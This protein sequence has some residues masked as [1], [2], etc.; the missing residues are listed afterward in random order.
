MYQLLRQPCDPRGDR[1]NCGGH[2]W[3]WY[4]PTYPFHY[5]FPT[6]TIAGISKRKASALKGEDMNTLVIYDSHYGNTE[7]V[8]QII[9]DTLR[10]FGQA[11]AVRV[12]PA[13]DS[14][15]QG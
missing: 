10:P 12:D 4:L 11:R 6:I 1:Y 7:R 13:R 2:V 3:E 5:P 8:A 14:E 9:A 15:V